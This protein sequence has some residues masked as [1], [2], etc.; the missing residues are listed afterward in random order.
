M[1]LP[2]IGT[3]PPSAAPDAGLTPDILVTP[4]PS[5]IVTGED[6]EM[7]AAMRVARP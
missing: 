6:P 4:A 2:L 1:D 3:F 7:A 5:D